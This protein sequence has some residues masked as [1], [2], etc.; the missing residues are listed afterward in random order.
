MHLRDKREGE[1]HVLHKIR[2]NT[3]RIRFIEAIASKWPLA[4]KK[5]TV[6]IPR[7]LLSLVAG[8]FYLAPSAADWVYPNAPTQLAWFY[9]PPIDGSTS[10]Q[11]AAS[12]QNFILT[13]NDE[14]YRDQL[15]TLGVTAPFMQYVRSDA[16]HDPCKG[17]CPC[18]IQP[19]GNQVAWTIGDYCSIFSSHPEWFLRDTSGAIIK[20]TD[21]DQLYAAMDPGNIGWQQFFLSRVKTS[22]ETMGWDGLFLD[23]LQAGLGQF[24]LKNIV[25]QKYPDDA[26]LRFAAQNFTATLYNS[27]FHPQNRPL[28]ANITSLPWLTETSAWFE[29]LQYLDGAMEESFA[30]GWHSGEWL[31]TEQWGDQLSRLDVSQS[32]GKRV[33][34]VSQ[35]SQTET[36]RQN[37]GFASYLL[38]AN[39][40]SS[41]RYTGTVDDEYEYVWLYPNYTTA[42]ALGAPLGRRYNDLANNAWRR[43]F[44]HGY[45]LVYPVNH[46]A[47]IVISTAPP[48]TTTPLHVSRLG[49]WYTDRYVVSTEVRIH[50]ASGGYP[51]ANSSVSL[52]TKLPNGKTSLTIGTADQWGIA[53]FSVKSTLKGT[54]TS[55]VT[56][57]TGSNVSYDAS[58]NV[59]TTVTKTVK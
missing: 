3:M 28:Q 46:V 47:T 25:L 31:T 8:L 48:P 49:M 5:D 35:D 36:A 37:F 38:I 44:E 19:Y 11:L 26:S 18:S 20:L 2:S 24:Q 55:T 30:M 45:V 58:K 10:A 17:T 32:Q 54:Y 1:A 16:I 12:F 43:D 59:A 13:K 14:T 9:K 41:F 21:G 51:P 33:I 39:G 22:Q 6:S 57:I 52:S 29:L 40:L 15:K 56:N 4:K 27:Y 50:N 42:K 7:L 23:N 53:T 34:A